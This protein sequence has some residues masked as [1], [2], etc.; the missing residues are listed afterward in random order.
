MALPDVVD[1][2]VSLVPPPRDFTGALL[3][4]QAL[5]GLVVFGVWPTYQMAAHAVVAT[6]DLGRVTGWHRLSDNPPRRIV[7]TE[8]GRVA[9]ADLWQ[10]QLQQR[11][12]LRS[13]HNGEQLLC[14]HGAPL[15]GGDVTEAETGCVPVL[16]PAV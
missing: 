4:A 12:E 11:L 1:N 14:P 16:Q 13:L 7:I 8:Q 5:F 9:F 2:A 15:S 6:R 3:I 10:P